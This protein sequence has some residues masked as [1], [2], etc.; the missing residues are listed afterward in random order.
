[1]VHE[2]SCMGGRNA[3]AVGVCI[4]LHLRSVLCA[5]VV[6]DFAGVGHDAF[7]IVGGVISF[8]NPNIMYHSID[9]PH[10]S[11]AGVSTGLQ[12]NSRIQI[13]SLFSVHRFH[14]TAVIITWLI[15]INFHTLT[16]NVIDRYSNWTTL[17]KASGMIHNIMYR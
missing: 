1:M 11:K 5:V 16:Q 13:S 2:F 9:E 3:V 14:C 15:R 10:Y 8:I 7:V 6:V 12:I 4:M 17:E